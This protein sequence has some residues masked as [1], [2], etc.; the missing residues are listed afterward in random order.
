MPIATPSPCTR[1]STSR[2]A[3]ERV[4][5]RASNCCS[6]GRMVPARAFA[7]SGL[8][9]LVVAVIGIL[10]EQQLTGDLIVF[11]ALAV[12][13]IVVLLV[14]VGWRYLRQRVLEL[15][16]PAMAEKLPPAA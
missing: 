13:G 14:G 2:T 9:A 16:P 3:P 15:F 11:M 8:V 5:W 7:T 1:T 12:V 10:K 4:R 6:P